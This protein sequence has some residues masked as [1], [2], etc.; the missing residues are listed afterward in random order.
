MLVDSSAVSSC[1]L[2][3]LLR[4]SIPWVEVIQVSSDWQ[5]ERLHWGFA[6]IWAFT[7]YSVTVRARDGSTVQHGVVNKD[8]ARFLNALR[9]FVPREAFDAGLYDWHP[10]MATNS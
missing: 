2:F 1:S 10:K 6:A 4:R 3:G 9:R 8:Q 5:E 7:G